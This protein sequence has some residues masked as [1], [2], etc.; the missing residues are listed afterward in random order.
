VEKINILLMHDGND[1]DKCKGNNRMV[2]AINF[3][4]PAIISRT[5][6][7]E[8]TAKAL[9]VEDALFSDATE[10]IS[11]INNFRSLQSRLQYIER[12]QK[13][14]WEKFSPQ[15]VAK[16]FMGVLINDSC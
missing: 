13:P 7:Y 4:V 12:A 9:N 5:P 6:E 16:R 15:V 11:A 10:L 8:I 2:T 14:C 3:A 1:E